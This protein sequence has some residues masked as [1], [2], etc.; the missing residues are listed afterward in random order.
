LGLDI[1]IIH[2]PFGERRERLSGTYTFRPA[3][4]RNLFDGRH[5]SSKVVQ[6]LAAFADRDT[7]KERG[8]TGSMLSKKRNTV[9]VTGLIR[10]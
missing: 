6:V 8:D 3:T 5:G 2:T 10:E 9:Y 4:A 1:C 7:G